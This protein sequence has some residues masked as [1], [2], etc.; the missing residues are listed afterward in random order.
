MFAPTRARRDA[1]TGDSRGAVSARESSAA[2][3]P[4]ENA[5]EPGAL[6][7]HRRLGEPAERDGGEQDAVDL[8]QGA[9]PVAIERRA[10]TAGAAAAFADVLH[11]AGERVFELATQP[12]ALAAKQLDGGTQTADQ[13]EGEIESE[14]RHERSPVGGFAAPSGSAVTRA[15]MTRWRSS[16]VRARVARAVPRQGEEP[17]QD[18]ARAVR[19]RSLPVIR[20][21]HTMELAAVRRSE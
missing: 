2:L 18:A 12:R 15:G 5:A 1:G 3:E 6:S 17:P 7:R 4:V 14:K 16:E 8:A 20:G 21:P 9:E 11:D 19:S 10:I 13:I